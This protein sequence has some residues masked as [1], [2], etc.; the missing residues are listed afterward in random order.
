[1]AGIKPRTINEFLTT[2]SFPKDMIFSQIS[3]LVD[4]GFLQHLP[5]DTYVNPAP[6][7]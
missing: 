2:L 3:F 5:D 6:R 7:R 1:M 4:E